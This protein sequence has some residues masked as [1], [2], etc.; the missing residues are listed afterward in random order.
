MAD[1]Y[2]P[3]DNDGSRVRTSVRLPEEQ[4][5][6]IEL[7]SE[8]WNE[9]DRALGNRRAKKWKAASVIER[10]VR[11]GIEGFWAQAGG[12]PSTEAARAE[13]VRRVVAEAKKSAA[14]KTNG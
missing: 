14:K 8:L 10:L 11:V 1:N 4:H 9:L 2:Y 12:R 3:I 7:M 5:E 6:D 13:M